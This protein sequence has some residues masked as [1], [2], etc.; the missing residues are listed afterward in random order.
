MG[1]TT[2]NP[3]SLNQNRAHAHYDSAVPIKKR[4]RNAELTP[5]ELASLERV[6]EAA[7]QL[8]DAERARDRAHAR[9]VEVM[10]AEWTAHLHA[11]GA[12]RVAREVGEDLFSEGTVRNYTSD[13]RAHGRAS[14]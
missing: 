12:T 13:L 7:R 6:K 14:E 8:A 1:S 5:A 3:A 9:R 4:P 11:L 10:R 2:R